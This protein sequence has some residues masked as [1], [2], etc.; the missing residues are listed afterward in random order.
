MS[1]HQPY[2][3]RRK[4][5]LDK[6]GHGIAILPT[7]PE[8]LRN[9]DA[10]HPYRFDSYFWYLTGFPE[11]EAVLVLVGGNRPQSI[12]FCRDKNDERE[13]WDGF[14]HGPQG[15]CAAFGF[16]AAYPIAELDTKLGELLA[17]RPTLWYALGHDAEW[18]ARITAALN[19][20][21][22]QSRAGKRAPAEIRDL[23]VPLDAMRLTK[24]AHELD[25]MRRAAAISSAG[26]ARAMHA[27]CPGMAEYELEAELTYEFRRRG[28]E[29]HAYTPIVAGGL[30]ACVLHYI[31]NDK[32]LNDHTLV[33]IDAGCEVEGYASDITRTFPVNGRFSAV[34]RD[35]YEIVLAAQ[36]AAIAAIKPGNHFM[37]P[38]NAA[39]RVLAQGMLDLKLLAGTLDGVIESED[40]K[41]FYMHRTGHWLGLDVHDAGEY[42]EGDAWTTLAPGMTLTVEPGI[43]IRPGADIP[44]EMVGIGI[45]IED[46]VLVTGQGCEVYTSAPKTVAEIEEIMLHG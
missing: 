39:L 18:D 12:L 33:L 13:I 42:K 40:Y 24:D 2:S 8:K 22:A 19:A 32:L 20:V 38:H 14:R 43:Y 16:D 26:H 46:D 41:R 37:D 17:D 30:N 25:A 4:H 27:C 15:A 28:A 9:R 21:R 5:L 44:P 34:Q 1:S 6:I 29:A 3:L 45:R 23:R 35:V 31:S 10:H 36:A 7:A 11:P